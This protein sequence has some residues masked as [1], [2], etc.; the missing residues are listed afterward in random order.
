MIPQNEFSLK[1]SLPFSLFLFLHLISILGLRITTV[2]SLCYFACP[3]GFSFLLGI[4]VLLGHA[5]FCGLGIDLNL[6]F[7]VLTDLAPGHS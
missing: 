1:F 4:A 6:S 3:P 5:C 2:V 7:C